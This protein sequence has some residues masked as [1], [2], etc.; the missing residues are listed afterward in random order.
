MKNKC[1]YG[2]TQQEEL[3]LDILC[4]VFQEKLYLDRKKAYTEYFFDLLRNQQV[5]E[6]NKLLLLLLLLF[7]F[8][9]QEVH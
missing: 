2:R 6:C 1:T 9:R 8:L 7:F 4:R 3:F 5:L